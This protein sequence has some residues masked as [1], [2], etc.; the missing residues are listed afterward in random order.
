MIYLT[1]IGRRHQF[2]DERFES[3]PARSE[4]IEDDPV[5]ALFAPGGPGVVKLR[6]GEGVGTD[7][8]DAAGVDIFVVVY[9]NI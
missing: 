2:A 1:C 8:S 6:T 7:K 5:V 3:Y 4:Q 9:G